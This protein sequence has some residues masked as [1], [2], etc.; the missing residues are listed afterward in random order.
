MN[1]DSFEFNFSSIYDELNFT[2]STTTDFILDPS[3]QPCDSAALSN[4]AAVAVSVFYVLVFLLAIPGNLVV[5][6][7]IGRNPQPLSPSDLFLLHLAVADVL[8]ATTLPFWATSVTWGWVFGDALCKL[9]SV[10]QELS[11]YVSILFLA[12]IS[13]DRYLAIV[14]AMDARRASRKLVSWCVCAAVWLAGGLLSLPGLLNSATL[15]TNSTNGSHFTCKEHYDPSSANRWRLATRG[16]S[17]TLGFALPLAV[18]LLCY[19]VTLRRLL[20]TKGSFQRQRAMRV[21]VAVVLAF[22]VCW[23]PYHLTVIADTFLRAK[24]VLY[25]CPTRNV[26]ERAQFVTQSLGLLHS[27]VNP[28]LYAFVGEKFRRRLE[29]LVKRT[30]LLQRASTA[31]PSRSSLSP[32]ITSTIM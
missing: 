28:V 14:H 5:G 18:M 7:V 23:T 21:I 30:G 9:V 20:R 13:V 19:G 10:L 25:E 4:A 2:Y 16:L 26:I 32:E 31:R 8:L 29:H 11:F 27:C 6:L 22:L 1:K 12:C 15:D 17:H 24:V 3:T